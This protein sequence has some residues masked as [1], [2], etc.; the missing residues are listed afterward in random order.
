[1]NAEDAPNC[2]SQI[3]VALIGR[4]QRGW[5]PIASMA[6]LAA[7]CL[8][9]RFLAVDDIAPL[10]R[11]RKARLL[12]PRRRAR[13]GHLL[14]IAPVPGALDAIVRDIPVQ[15]RYTTISAWVID[16]FW[17]ERIPRVARSGWIDHFYVMDA[18]DVPAWEKAT[19]RPASPLPWG[20]DVLAAGERIT[21]SRSVDLLR[22]GRQPPA[23][24][25][26]ERT[27]RVASELGI[28]FAGRPPF[29][30]DERSSQ[31]ALHASLSIA[32]TVLAFS[33]RVSPAAYTHPHREYI[34]GRW[35]DAL[36]HGCLVAGVLPQCASE[37]E[38]VPDDAQLTL[39]HND[40]QSG[41]DLIAERTRDWSPDLSARIHEHA[42]AHIDWAHR[43]ETIAQDLRLTTPRL[44]ERLTLLS[45]PL[46]LGE[47]RSAT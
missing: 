45:K 24:D 15:G 25:D 3:D 46:A 7:D 40:L 11:A 19:G 31:Q 32:R 28:R 44:E 23:W 42:R 27:A 8:G 6:P 37:R 36:A 30:A 47:E 34:T 41:L 14:I 22:V 4:T 26:D 29:G 21:H 33:N 5:G 10:W 16:S 18:D 38:L 12:L 43:F 9:G 13:A 2:D 39:P 17:H 20:A 35:T 1:M